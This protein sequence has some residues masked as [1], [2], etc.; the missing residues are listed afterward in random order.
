[1]KV[2]GFLQEISGHVCACVR[3]LTR[4]LRSLSV[5]SAPPPVGG[6]LDSAVDLF[7]REIKREVRWC[8]MSAVSSRG[9]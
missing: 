9:R 8:V 3:V 7:R 5:C 4:S 1:M 6:R 2:L